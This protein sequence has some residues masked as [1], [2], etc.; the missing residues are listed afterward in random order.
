MQVL[1][2]ALYTFLMVPAFVSYNQGLFFVTTLMF[3]SGLTPL[4]KT[5][6]LSLL[7]LMVKSVSRAKA[8]GKVK[9]EEKASFSC[10]RFAAEQKIAKKF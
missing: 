1:H 10:S 8:W 4:G 3:D 6:S 7:E 5:T 9:N 2:T